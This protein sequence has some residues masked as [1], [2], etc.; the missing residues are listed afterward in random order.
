MKTSFFIGNDFPRTPP[1]K[2]R[3]LQQYGACVAADAMKGFNAMQHRIKPIASGLSICGCALTVR[4]QAG[5]NLL[6]HAAIEIA[7][8]GDVL[9]VDT[10]GCYDSAIIGSMMCRAAF[11]VRQIGGLVIDG[12]VRDIEDL[13]EQRYG[14]FAAGICPN[15]GSSEGPGMLNRSI[16]CGGVPVAPGD[17]IIGDDNGVTVVPSEQIDYVLDRC[18][19]RSLHEKQ[20]TEEIERQCVTAKGILTKLSAQGYL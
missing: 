14:I 17:V 18:A 19:E 8:P 3:A 9:V 4:L 2:L 15:T 20:R 5:D 16:S 13:R 6:L 10:G 7:K 11:H 12:A 1:E